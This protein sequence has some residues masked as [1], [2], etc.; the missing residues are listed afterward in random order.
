MAIKQVTHGIGYQFK[1]PITHLPRDITL[2]YLFW[3]P[4][5]QISRMQH[6]SKYFR[7]VIVIEGENLWQRLC[8]RDFPRR[9][10][11]QNTLSKLHYQTC[12]K[13][14]Q[15]WRKGRYVYQR[16]NNC[17]KILSLSGHHLFCASP[18]LT[19][20][21]WNLTDLTYQVLEG[22]LNGEVDTCIQD[23]A[24]LICVTDSTFS[25]ICWFQVWDKTTRQLLWSNNS[26]EKV[27]L[28]GTSLIVPLLCYDSKTSSFTCRIDF[29]DKS[30]GKVVGSINDTDI[31][32]SYTTRLVGSY[33]FAQK[34]RE[35]IKYWNKN[36]LEFVRRI[37]SAEDP[38]FAYKVDDKNLICGFRSGKIAILNLESGAL[39]RQLVDPTGEI[40]EIL[41][42]ETDEEVVLAIC[43]SSHIA[44]W[45]KQSGDLLFK[46]QKGTNEHTRIK[47]T[48]SHFIL[49]FLFEGH[50]EFRDK[51]TGSLLKTCTT[52]QNWFCFPCINDRRIFSL[53]QEKLLKIWDKQTGDLLFTLPADRCKVF[54]D[55]LIIQ[56]DQTVDVGDFSANPEIPFPHQGQLHAPPKS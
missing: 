4:G 52:G 42:I 6:V 33:L 40:K 47:L 9:I 39:L 48:R 12:F 55:R 51:R 26:Y 31:R 53:A 41:A 43:G 46:I 19:I 20:Q 29:C 45:D 11:P 38:L 5:N 27:Y 23:E 56:S 21:R 10:I 7:N 15:N 24:L 49:G 14:E 22:S 3:L 34:P 28:D 2:L 35:F 18:Q 30:T 50:F 36:T 44:C 17:G 16:L 54:G 13:T 32:F 8:Q 25:G 37:G 1:A